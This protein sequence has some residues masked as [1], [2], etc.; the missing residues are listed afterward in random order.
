MNMGRCAAPYR[1]EESIRLPA[2]PSSAAAA[3]TFVR[4]MLRR[5]NHTSL[6]DAALLCVTELVANVSVHTDSSECMVTVKD[7]DE[8]VVIEVTDEA[9]EVPAVEPLSDES[10]HGRGLRIVEALARDWGVLRHSDSGK[11]VWLQLC[12]PGGA[13]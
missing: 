11:S 7:S 9:L 2:E 1:W 3:R 13:G 5:S 8:D 6:E 10:E 12:D 4:D